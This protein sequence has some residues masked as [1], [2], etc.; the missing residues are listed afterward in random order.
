MTA[1]VLES[2]PWEVGVPYSTYFHPSRAAEVASWQRTL[3]RARRPWLFA[4]V[5]ARRPGDGGT[6]RG[7]V[8]DQCARSWRCGLL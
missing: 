5:G 7:S 2:G 1:L 6:L 4:F 8:I 3:R